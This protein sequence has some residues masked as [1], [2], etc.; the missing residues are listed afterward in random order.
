MLSC[1]LLQIL[2]GLVKCRVAAKGR[3]LKPEGRVHTGYSHGYVRHLAMT[4]QKSLP[5][6]T[7]IIIIVLETNK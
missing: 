3:R 5:H 4:E 7:A 1:F 6:P 2:T